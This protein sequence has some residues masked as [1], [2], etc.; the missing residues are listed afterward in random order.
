MFTSANQFS[1]FTLQLHPNILLDWKEQEGEVRGI[2]KNHEKG[3]NCQVNERANRPV[4]AAAWVLPPPRS[5]PR[6]P[7]AGHWKESQS[8]TEPFYQ[9][10]A[11][12][13]AEPCGLHNWEAFNTSDASETGCVLWKVLRLMHTD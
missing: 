10:C 1:A 12:A 11:D 8:A 9:L 13:S 7:G 6:S 3:L 5:W 4:P 2:V